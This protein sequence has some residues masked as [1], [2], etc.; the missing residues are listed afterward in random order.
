MAMP[1]HSGSAI[2]KTRKPATKSLAI[3]ADGRVDEL[4]ELEDEA[5]GPSSADEPEMMWRLRQSPHAV[6]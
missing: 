6:S 5:T 3:E 4:M 2:K 1:K